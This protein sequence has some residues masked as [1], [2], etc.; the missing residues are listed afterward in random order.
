MTTTLKPNKNLQRRTAKDKEEADQNLH[1]LR[2]EFPDRPCLET[3]S[4]TWSSWSGV[5]VDQREQCSR[6]S[7]NR[8][9][10]IFVYLVLLSG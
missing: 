10:V 5:F 3:S 6:R 2:E 4:R 8:P 9:V 7:G 1:P